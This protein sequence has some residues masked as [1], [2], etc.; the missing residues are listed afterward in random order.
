MELSES[1][2]LIDEIDDELIRL[3]E[4]RMAVCTEVANYKREHGLPVLDAAR[5]R[6]KLT[7]LAGKASPDMKSYIRVLYSLIFELSRSYQNKLLSSDSPLYKA[8]REAIDG[9]QRAFPKE[10]RIA[11]QGIEGAYSQAAC[12]KLFEFPDIHYY[13]SF[14]K[15]FAAIEA[16]EC[17]YGVLPLENSTAGSVNKVYDLMIEHDFSIVR[18]VRVKIDHNLM[19]K[20]GVK[21]EDIREICSHEQALN[22]C[23]KFIKSLGKNIKITPVANTAMAAEMVA[24][25]ER[26]D[27]AAIC[28]RSCADLY[29]LSCVQSSVQDAGNNHTR[30]ICISKNMEI[31]PGADK[32][33]LML[34]TAHKPGALYRVLSRFYAMG[35]NLQKL[36]SRPIPDKDFEF[37]FYFDLDTSIYSPE[38]VQLMCELD[39]LCDD[40][41]YLGSYT[42]MA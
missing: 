15:V 38:F 4:K 36:E 17:D 37:M 28:S 25:S 21:A 13:S 29:G 9:T 31:Y 20:P 35:I 33:S 30:F 32:T 14:G 2:K 19:A 23:S 18:S 10:A 7:D 40:F 6:S 42:E 5:E 26:G 3:F 39:G 12:E 11:C 24:K 22:Q 16:G 27:I 34:V 8:I 41:K 1:R